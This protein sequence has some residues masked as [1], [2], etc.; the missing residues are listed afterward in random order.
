MWLLSTDRAELR[1]FSRNFDA[2]GGYVILSHTWERNEQTFQDVEAISERCCRDGTNPRDFVHPK[3]RNCCILAEKQGYR[4]V[5]IDS[6]CIDKT[7]SSELSEA[8]N[9]M[10]QWYTEAEVCYAY[11]ADVPGDCVL[12]SPESAF[13]KSRWHTRGWTLQELIAPDFVIFLSGDWREL[14]NRAALAKLLQ[15]ITRVD[16]RV[17]TRELKPA[18]WS[19]SVRMSWASSRKT[20]RVEDEAYSLMGLFG[21]SMPTNYGEGKRAFIRLQYEIMQHDSDMSLFAFGY[22]VNQDDTEITFHAQDQVN[23][24]WQYLMADSP[25]ELDYGFG[26]IPDLGTN[27]KQQYPPPLVS[28]SLRS[29]PFPFT[30]TP[31]L[32]GLR[33]HWSFRR[34][35]APQR[36]C[37]QL[38]YPV[39]A[40]HP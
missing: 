32:T 8:I 40:T 27:A 28:L 25:R 29:A 30:D 2:E 26:Y 31:S 6:C 11:L 3:I 24:P 22:R 19:I 9:S 34:R 5:W 39:S 35:R 7:S 21:V 37:H 20:T 23:H 10:Y 38:R 17:L 36:H 1:Y 33:S 4:W 12:D 18:H 16:S 14:G 13:R 15:E